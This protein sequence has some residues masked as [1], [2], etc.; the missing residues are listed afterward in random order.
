MIRRSRHS[1][2]ALVAPR[3]YAFLAAALGAFLIG[4]SARAVD[5]AQAGGRRDATRVAIPALDPLLQAAAV[6]GSAEGARTLRVGPAAE[7]A[8][9]GAAAAAARDGDTI[10]IAAGEYRGDVAV[11]RSNRLKIVGV[12]G[13]PHIKADGQ[14]AEGKGVWVI[15]GEDTQVDNVEI[16]GAR[17]PDKN[18]AAIRL[19]G[20]NLIVRNSFFHDGEN[21]ILT[22]ADEHSEVVID[23]CEFARNG[24]GQGYAHNVYIGAIAKLTVRLSYLHHAVGGHNLKSRAAISLV[25]D[26][27]LADEGDGRASYEADFPNGGQVTLAFNVIQKG[28]GAPNSTL[29]SYGAEGLSNGKNSF[30][31]KGNTFVSQRPAGARFI[32]IVPGANPVDING[33]VFA[34]PGSLPDIAGVKSKNAVQNEM[35]GNVDWKPEGTR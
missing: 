28:P 24:D 4:T 32:A 8:A 9:P 12:G 3:R 33:N 26:N 23:R 29:V 20:R 16:S 35:P 10:E 30:V 27:R 25:S 19:E 18:G 17:V 5:P 11:W 22:G 13:R 15:K 6:T 21:G 34:G 31:A 14:S 1:A 7:Y 2:P